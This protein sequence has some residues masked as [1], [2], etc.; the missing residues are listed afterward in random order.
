[1][2]NPWRIA[3]Q[4]C[5]VAR[6]FR[7]LSF[8]RAGTIWTVAG[9]GG[10]VG[11]TGEGRG[12]TE[13]MRGL[14]EA[15]TG[16]V[17]SRRGEDARPVPARAIAAWLWCVAAMVLVTLVVGGATRLADA[18]LSIVEWRPVTGVLPPFTE[19]GWQA[20]LEKYRQ[21]PEYQLVNRGMSLAE[22]KV[23][24]WWEWGHRMAGRAI[25]LVFVL[26]LAFF[27]AR[28]MVP[29]WLK[30]RLLV[31]LALGGLQGFVGWWM[32]SSGLVD[33]VDVS[34]YRLA[35]HLTLACVILALTVWT[36][37]AV[38]ARE[39]PA[40]RGP[41]P[42]PSDGRIA[43]SRPQ[44]GA[45]VRAGSAVLLALVLVQIFLG[46]LV[47]GLDAGLASNT[48]PLMNG[49][50]APPGLLT[51]TPWWLN[52]F[53]NPLTVQFDHRVFG[54]LLWLFAAAHAV[55]A[56]RAAPT[57]AVA[58]RAGAILAVMT[59]QVG[60]GVATVV[61]GVP[62]DVALAHQLTGGVLVAMAAWHAQRTLTAPAEDAVSAAALR[63]A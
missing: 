51:L 24:Y 45:L 31:L 56:I 54:Y 14:E 25:G 22:F 61:L 49:A 15:P 46:G 52:L 18:G 27:W 26:P 41:V 58:R 37:A 5:D 36:A 4:S 1:M 47:A 34:Q 29:G 9:G 63:P 39:G 43:R 19:A 11:L 42:S 16:A 62:V 6:A 33:R 32:V 3:I 10:A 60:I 38:L 55:A 8:P 20:E 30:P 12:T 44:G 17:A 57:S 35:T 13:T 28:G 40:A 53:E 59:A 7:R 21:I 48:W 50:L 2:A 23:I